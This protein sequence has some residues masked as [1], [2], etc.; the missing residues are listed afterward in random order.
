ME[1]AVKQI[2][3]T[4]GGFVTVDADLFDYLKRWK[5]RK[6]KQG[7]AVRSSYD[8]GRSITIRMH[9]LIAKTPDGMETDH[10]NGNRLD[11]RRV[12]LRN[13][14]VNQN[15]WNSSKTSRNKSGYKGVY[16]SDYHK[17]WRAEIA[18]RGK[19]EFIGLFPDPLSG[20]KA[21]NAA[22]IRLFGPYARLNR[23]PD[24]G[25]PEAS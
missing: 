23:I 2:P 7:Y 6:S 20:A 21:Y 4:K 11:N 15:H 25:L 12:N 17:A 5:W 9:R 18:C 16:W 13:V 10:I 14:S 8:R 24:A 19:K 22:A 1:E 3:L